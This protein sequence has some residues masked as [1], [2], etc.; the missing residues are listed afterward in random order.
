MLTIS[1]YINQYLAVLN[2][3]RGYLAK[4]GVHNVESY[5]SDRL[6]KRLQD[7]FGSDIQIVAQRGKASI[8][9]SSSIPLRELCALA[10]KQQRELNK[11]ESLVRMQ[12]SRVGTVVEHSPSTNVARVRFPDSA[13]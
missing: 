3:Y 7:H 2:S 9:C 12:G 8:V 10:A 13:S 6:K 1:T 11:S 4:R 5:R